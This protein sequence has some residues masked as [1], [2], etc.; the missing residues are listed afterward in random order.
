[1]FL[2]T[3]FQADHYKSLRNTMVE[4]QLVSRGIG[5]KAVLD[6]MRKVPRHLLVPEKIKDFAY[7]DRPLPIG[8]GQTISQ[9]YIVAFMTELIKPHP[10][11]KVL[12]IGTG[13]G[14]Q[15]AV[16]AEIVREVFTIEIFEGL[17]KRA[18]RDLQN[19]G[20]QNIQVRIGDGYKGWPEEAPF[21]AI[22]VTAAPSEIP[23]PLIEQLKDGGSMIIPVGQEGKI[24][25][26]I[27]GEKKNGKF[28]TRTVSNVQFVP[29]LREQKKS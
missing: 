20:Y 21:D 25:Q 28:K 5:D 1:M 26:L 18:S 29:F 23:Q 14:Y 7:D 8:E 22:I 11:M 19:L 12:E 3:V 9:P 27:L 16:L 4:T 24:Q 17:G 2:V 15:A 13:S 10:E 6:A